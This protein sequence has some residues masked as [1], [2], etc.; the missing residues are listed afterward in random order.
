MVVILVLLS[1][2]TCW[3]SDPTLVAPHGEEAEILARHCG[4]MEIATSPFCKWRR[5]FLSQSETVGAQRGANLV[6]RLW[7][8]PQPLQGVGHSK[9]SKM[10]GTKHRSR[11]CEEALQDMRGAIHQLIE[12]ARAPVPSEKELRKAL[13]AMRDCDERLNPYKPQLT[14]DEKRIFIEPFH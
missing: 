14:Y 7:P 10:S 2:T 8:E 6:R 12:A 9:P 1:W 11:A 5:D 13:V 4:W 3:S